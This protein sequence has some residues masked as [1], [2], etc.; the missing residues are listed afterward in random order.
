MSMV[1]MA[2]ICMTFIAMELGLDSTDSNI[3]DEKLGDTITN[4]G[5]TL[6]II[7]VV[8]IYTCKT[9]GE[10]GLGDVHTTLQKGLQKGLDT[11]KTKSLSIDNIAN[12]TEKLAQNAAMAGFNFY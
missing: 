5:I 4:Y 8:M 10:Q 6:I 12:E 9:C 3:T 2:I 1:V 11:S 7:G